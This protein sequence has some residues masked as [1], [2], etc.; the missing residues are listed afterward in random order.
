MYG[1]STKHYTN[2]FPLNKTEVK[3]ESPD[4]GVEDVVG[5]KEEKIKGGNNGEGAEC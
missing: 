2:C 3:R 4:R 1:L 5:G